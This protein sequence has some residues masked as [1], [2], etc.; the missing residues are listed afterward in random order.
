[1]RDTCALSWFSSLASILSA[2]VLRLLCVGVLEYLLTLV[3][4]GIAIIVVKKLGKHQKP[5]AIQAVPQSYGAPVGYA[6][7]G[8]AAAAGAYMAQ[9]GGSPSFDEVRQLLYKCVRDVSI[10][11]VLRRSRG[12]VSRTI[13]GR[14]TRLSTDTGFRRGEVLTSSN[15]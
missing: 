7:A 3:L 2:W 4:A 1:M 8:A 9:G 12:T 13:G 5:Q 15:T 6:A 11:T 14:A 10:T